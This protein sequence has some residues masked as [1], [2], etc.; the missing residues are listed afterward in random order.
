MVRTQWGVHCLRAP[1]VCYM[2]WGYVCPCL[3]AQDI[4]HGQAEGKS[5][6]PIVCL[7]FLILRGLPREGGD[8]W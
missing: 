5:R 6:C 7:H 2:E 3:A 1:W 4:G 8:I